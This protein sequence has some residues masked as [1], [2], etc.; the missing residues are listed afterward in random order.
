MG[1]LFRSMA[2]F[3]VALSGVAFAYTMVWLGSRGWHWSDGAAVVT[4]L[5]AVAALFLVCISFRDQST[6]RSVNVSLTILAITA[7]LYVIF[8]RGVG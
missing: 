8:P 4:S 7:A 6:R 5:L 3:A 1:V 2:N